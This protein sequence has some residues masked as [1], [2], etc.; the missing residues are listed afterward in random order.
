MSRSIDLFIDA[1]LDLDELAAEITKLTGCELAEVPGRRGRVLTS[2]DVVAELD[3]HDFVDDRELL[4][5]RYRYVLTATVASDRSVN[6]SPQAALLR[7]IFAAMKADH[8]YPCLLVFDLQH[9]MD[10]SGPPPSQP[11]SQPVT[12]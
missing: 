7:R 9:L 2:G 6:D 11:P 10:R 1:P 3:D 5:S 8:R 4:F 12:P